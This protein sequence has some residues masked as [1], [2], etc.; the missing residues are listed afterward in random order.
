MSYF[1][2]FHQFHPI[3]RA[4]EARFAGGEVIVFRILVFWSKKEGALM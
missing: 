2:Q 1:I 3:E 4:S